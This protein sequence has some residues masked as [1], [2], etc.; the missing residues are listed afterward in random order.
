MFFRLPSKWYG[1]QH[2]TPFKC[3]VVCLSGSFKFI[4][5]AGEELI[6]RAGD[7]VLDLNTTGKGHATAVMSD[8]PAEGLIVRFE[9]L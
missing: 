6:M 8:E 2:P 4:G 3:L 9:G 7:R 5:S 1:E